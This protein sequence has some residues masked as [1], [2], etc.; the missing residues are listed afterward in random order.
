VLKTAHT[1]VLRILKIP[2]NI[3]LSDFKLLPRLHYAA[4]G[5]T[6]QFS[7]CWLWMS[8]CFL[9]SVL[10]VPNPLSRLLSCFSSKFYT[11]PACTMLW[12]RQEEPS[13]LL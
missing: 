12:E 8:Q 13:I 7:H 5:R 1:Y 2:T 3:F 10:E 4:N 11:V 6:L 9:L